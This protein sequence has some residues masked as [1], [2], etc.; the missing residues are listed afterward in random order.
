MQNAAFSVRPQD[1]KASDGHKP[2][3]ST[4]ADGNYLSSSVAVLCNASSILMST[5]V[6]KAAQILFMW[7][8]TFLFKAEWTENS[9]SKLE[10]VHQMTQSN[11][12]E[13]HKFSV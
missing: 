8:N 10:V 5:E 12:K 1:Q 2:V 3:L 9:T 13:I 11:Y 6:P 7:R 4:A